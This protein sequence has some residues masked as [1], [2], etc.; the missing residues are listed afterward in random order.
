MRLFFSPD[1]LLHILI[2][3]SPKTRFL[4]LSLVGAGVIAIPGGIFLALPTSSSPDVVFEKQSADSGMAVL[5]AQTENPNFV[6]NVNVPSFFSDDVSI[7][8]GLTVK[9]KA[10]FDEGI[11]LPNQDLDLGE[12]I[13][14]AGNVLYSLEAGDG[15]SLS[16][17]QTPTITNSGV[18]SLQGKTGALTFSAGSGISIDGLTISSSSTVDAFKNIAVLGQSTVSAGSSTD[19]LTFAGGSGINLTTDANS[20]TVT[21]SSDGSSSSQWDTS[22]NDI[23]YADGN[24]GIGST[25]PAAKLDVNGGIAI[26][27]TQVIDSSRNLSNVGEVNTDL[28]PGSNNTYDLGSSDNQWN[29]IYGQNLYLA[30]NLITSGAPGGGSLAS[31]TSSGA[32]VLRVSDN[33]V[34]FGGRT[35]MKTDDTNLA[36]TVAVFAY[37]TGRDID[38]GKW[39][40]SDRVQSTS[41]YSETVDHDNQTCVLTTD[42]RCGSKAFP[43]KASL[44]VTSSTLYLFD[45]LDNT[46]WMKFSR[47]TG[48]AMN[49][50][51]VTLTSVYALNGVIYIGTSENGLIAIDLI[52]DQIYQYDHNGDSGGR[53]SFKGNIA[54][55]NS[56]RGFGPRDS[57]GEISADK[58]NGV[59]A[60]LIRGKLYVVASTL[61]G[62]SVIN[63]T[64]HRVIRYIDN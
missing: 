11:S 35:T 28:T 39:V 41:W 48:Y 7:Q 9:G 57:W 18:L 4:V 22:G 63:V 43:Q 37:D 31:F 51:S 2:N 62:A 17:G 36:N 58:V 20:K 52:N 64:D 12:G 6:F 5:A 47:G 55:R 56:N 33:D 61:T 1:K 24:V 25:A 16:P 44:V 59:T 21:I 32:A 13:L 34:F 46:L 26:S 60:R 14:T 30:G 27:G 54:S 42:D 40:K 29:N 8:G 15:I 38:G 49:G 50:T 45:T 3:S 10:V 19:T 23:N 53:A